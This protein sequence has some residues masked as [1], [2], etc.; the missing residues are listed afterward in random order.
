MEYVS[1][2]ADREAAV[3]RLLR[4]SFKAPAGVVP[5]GQCLDAEMLAAWVDGALKG[6]ELKA[7]EAHLSECSRCMALLATMIKTLPEPEPVKRW[8]GTSSLR[9]LVPLT[10]GAAAVLVWIAVPRDNPR[11]LPE[12]TI[13]RTEAIPVAPAIQEPATEQRPEGKAED[14]LR[15][16]TDERR[17]DDKAVEQRLDDKQVERRDEPAKPTEAPQALNERVTIRQEPGAVA[18]QSGQ[19][20][21]FKAEREAATPPPPATPSAAPPSPAASAE[22]DRAAAAEAARQPITSSGATP[23]RPQSA[24]LVAA[25]PADLGRANSAIPMSEIVSPDSAIRWRAGA[26][27]FV[28]L[29]QNG[30]TTWQS[31]NS[32]VTVDLIAGSSPSPTVCWLVG[33]AGTVLVTTDGRNWRQ[34]TIPETAD[35]TSVRATDARRAIVTA[36]DGRSFTTTDGGLTWTR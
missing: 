35:L 11:Q 21:M 28:Q 13:A 25:R 3:E 8:W 33:R 27:G 5:R 31:L 19:S 26:R 10:A 36:S 14:T 22:A 7:T 23:A 24:P 4:Q 34:V 30:G 6:G 12:Q 15:F 1:R 20:A 2:G 29:S 9:W 17:L 32:G 16:R 18:G